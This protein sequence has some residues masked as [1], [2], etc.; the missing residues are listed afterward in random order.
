MRFTIF[1]AILFS[2]FFGTAQTVIEGNAPGFKNKYVSFLTIEDY[3]TNSYKS[4]GKQKIDSLGKFNFST[5]AEHA[6]R[7]IIEIEE[8]SAILYIDPTTKLYKIHFPSHNNESNIT[9]LVFEDIPKNDLNTLILEFNLRFDDFLYGDTTKMMRLVMQNNVF[10]DSLDVF[11][12]S[13]LKHYKPINNQY[14][15]NYIKYSIASVEQLSTGN[16]IAINRLH[17]YNNYLKDKPVLY[18]NDAYMIFFN[19][20][21]ENTLKAPVKGGKDQLYVAINNNA[22]Q[23]LLDEIFIQD[24]FLKDDKI[25]EI[26]MIKGVA[27]EYYSDNFIKKNLLLILQSIADKT[28]FSENKIIAD[29]AIKVITKLQKGYAAPDFTLTNSKKDSISIQKFKGK[30]VYLNFFATWN[31]GSIQELEVIQDLEKKYGKYI[32]FISISI[33]KEEEAFKAFIKQHPKYKWNLIHYQGEVGLLS[34]YRISSLP[35]YFLID[36][37]GNILQAPAYKPT[38]NNNYES[39]DKTFFDIKKK[40]E[41]K[42]KRNIGGR[43]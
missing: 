30:H 23:L 20:F 14:F 17:V 39:I 4:L 33:D 19:Q 8:K 28:N 40:L 2:H 27:E 18:H 21:Y 10:K 26:A 7:A 32:E 38:P 1:L 42:N 22:S 13:L 6:F 9:K 25:R 43:N 36:P 5:D 11:K 29:N 15:H 16:N 41:P 37:E 34:D 24:V 35:E 12:N 31:S 3:V